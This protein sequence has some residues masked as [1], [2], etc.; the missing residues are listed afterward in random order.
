ML[1]PNKLNKIQFFLLAVFGV[2]VFGSSMLKAQVYLPSDSVQIAPPTVHD[3]DAFKGHTEEAGGLGART[4]IQRGDSWGILFHRIN[5][6]EVDPGNHIRFTYQIKA[7][8]EPGAIGSAIRDESDKLG[9]ALASLGFDLV[10]KGGALGTNILA[11]C[12]VETNDFVTATG[13]RG[14]PGFL[15][16]TGA[17]I[18]AVSSAGVQL[19][20]TGT[21]DSARPNRMLLEW[22]NSGLLTGALQDASGTE[23]LVIGIQ[24]GQQVV[25]RRVP[26][27]GNYYAVDH[28]E[29]T[30]VAMFECPLMSGHENSPAQMAFGP[31]TVT[32]SGTQKTGDGVS[33]PFVN[34]AENNLWYYPLDGNPA[35]IDLEVGGGGDNFYVDVT[36]SE[37]VRASGGGPV[38]MEQ[39]ESAVYLIPR[40]ATQPVDGQHLA[41]KSVTRPS[42]A[43]VQVGDTVVRVQLEDPSADAGRITSDPNLLIS[44]SPLLVVAS[45]DGSGHHRTPDWWVRAWYDHQAPYIETA[46][47]G[48]GSEYVDI[49]FNQGVKFGVDFDSNNPPQ[50]VMTGTTAPVP[51]DFVIRFYDRSEGTV[52]DYS[53]ASVTNPSDGSA[54]TVEASVGVTALRLGMHPD[55]IEAYEPID[56]ID[57]RTAQR[58]KDIEHPSLASVFVYGADNLSTPGDT[59]L[60]EFRKNSKFATEAGD[61]NYPRTAAFAQVGSLRLKGREFYLTVDFGSEAA[62][63]AAG[64]PAKAFSAS[65][66]SVEGSSLESEER[67]IVRLSGDGLIFPGGNLTFTALDAPQNFQVRA[68]QTATGTPDII[69]ALVNDLEKTAVSSTP[70]LSLSINRTFTLSFSRSNVEVVIDGDAVSFQVGL[71]GDATALLVDSETLS[72]DV[73]WQ[74]APL[75]DVT[76]G[77]GQSISVSLSS[78]PMGESTTIRVQAG[79]GAGDGDSGSLAI[80]NVN[81]SISGATIAITSDATI[82]I[83]VI[84]EQDVE[85]QFGVSEV[86][87]P[88]GASMTVEVY[89]DQRALQGV[90]DRVAVDFSVMN[91]PTDTIRVEP[92][93]L[94]F[95]SSH[96]QGNPQ[97]LTITAGQRDNAFLG[98]VR[99][100]A[101]VTEAQQTALGNITPVPRR[102]I[103]SDITIGLALN[104]ATADEFAGHIAETSAAGARSILDGKYIIVPGT[105]ERMNLNLPRPSLDISP[106]FVY[107]CVED[108]SNDCMDGEDFTK[109]TVTEVTEAEG[110]E[111]EAGNFENTV[112]W[113]AVDGSA[114]QK[115]GSQKVYV[116]PP[117]GFRSSVRVYE[118]SAIELGLSV[119]GGL[120]DEIE[121]VIENEETGS[122][123]VIT[124]TP[125]TGGAL[126]PY[127]HTI[128][129]GEVT[130][131]IEEINGVAFDETT[132]DPS[133]V[134]LSMLISN[135]GLFSIGNRKLVLVASSPL[136]DLE[137]LD[138]LGARL[139]PFFMKTGS[140]HQGFQSALPGASQGS[141][142][143]EMALTLYRFIGG[144][145]PTFSVDRSTPISVSVGSVVGPN[146][147]FP[148]LTNPIGD[149]PIG[150]FFEV[151]VSTSTETLDGTVYRGSV[152]EDGI[153]VSSG[154]LRG[155]YTR[156]DG[157][158]QGVSEQNLNMELSQPIDVA[159]QENWGI[160][161]LPDGTPVS[162][163]GRDVF[164]YMVTGLGESEAVSIVLE[165]SAEVTESGLWPHK[166]GYSTDATEQKW[167]EFIVTETDKIY[168]A[169]APC[170]SAHASRCDSGGSCAWPEV[171]RNSG[172]PVQHGCI[173]L[174]I[175]EGG[176]NDADR[177]VNGVLHDPMGLSVVS[178]GR[179]GGGGGAIDPTL[180]ILLA[181]GV[182]L[183]SALRRRRRCAASSE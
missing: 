83:D 117:V 158:V 19:G 178:G 175:Q 129:E 21:D 162:E 87:V 94:T 38:G 170:P 113:A 67:A 166:Y 142:T 60:A 8:Q 122:S 84:Q 63:L 72:F 17:V 82:A 68:A 131:T 79:P 28:E 183:A 52:Q 165:L 78:V 145:T 181:A 98:D 130:F 97:T 138:N 119:A 20:Y 146:D 32:E 163:V 89:L 62:E 29:Y 159:L 114:V 6:E 123:Q 152:I 134:D 7:G 120:T 118:G 95:D 177:L 155:V 71:L 157:K 85:V 108:G 23:G 147:F 36:F 137:V 57:I 48:G 86:V 172:V 93:R 64:G 128:V 101:S 109:T 75:T 70:G 4:T 55:I 174:Q 127:T 42:G 3:P 30:T 179:G 81:H 96:V 140:P 173:L 76:V 44:T 18:T 139:D 161:P 24:G 51:E 53:P 169:P 156:A 176:M 143:V 10:Y 9:N 34:Y 168:S 115:L 1:S 5:V 33:R 111:V 54:I 180:L 47:V 136:N 26:L 110:V 104:F 46:V 37:G 171:T 116:A 22:S 132:Y 56:T 50:A 141:N 31:F 99:L 133:A 73:G 91:D 59:S 11:G 2:T 90:S 144:A 149:L 27:S 182:L 77:G 154:L 151:T 39:F 105:G 164:D 61:T 106:E 153:P 88:I 25:E 14:A 103:E 69:S 40:T 43:P 135:Q 121:L 126:P 45:D 16:G 49:T 74:G 92:S 107:F 160:P 125:G 150:S 80:S 35:I 100:A 102:F 58:L 12:T 41:V 112:H 148:T 13:Y 167:G 66:K 15:V 124:S 65:L